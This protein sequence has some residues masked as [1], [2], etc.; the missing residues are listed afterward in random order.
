MK[1]PSSFGILCRIFA[2][3]NNSRDA[4]TTSQSK[5]ELKD[6]FEYSARL[7]RLTEKE[8]L[9]NSAGSYDVQINALNWETP[10]LSSISLD[11]SWGAHVGNGYIGFAGVAHCPFTG[12]THS[13]SNLTSLAKYRVTDRIETEASLTVG[14]N[15]QA[16]A[17]V[18][19]Q[20]SPSS[21]FRVSVMTANAAHLP[22]I[23]FF[24]SRQLTFHTTLFL[25]YS[26]SDDSGKDLGS[27]FDNYRLRN[28]SCRLGLIHM[29]SKKSLVNLNIQTGT[30]ESFVSASYSQ[31]VF[32]GIRFKAN[33]ELNTL[34][35]LTVGLQTEKRVTEYTKIG[36]GY[37]LS[38]STGLLLK[39]RLKRL[40]RRITVPLYLSRHFDLRQTIVLSVAIPL[41]QFIS[42]QA[43]FLPQYLKQ[44]EKEMTQQREEY[45]DTLLI[46]KKDAQDAVDV[47]F[48]SVMKKQELERQKHGLVILLAVYGK[49]PA[50][51]PL[52]DLKHLN[53]S[54]SNY[55]DVTIPVASLVQKSQ[56]FVPSRSK[57][58][59][60][61]F[62]DPCYPEEKHLAV[63]YLFHNR[64][65]FVKMR[66]R[67][68]LVAPLRSHVIAE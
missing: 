61:G 22:A 19:A 49:L 55:I 23:S 27:I 54:G 66:D 4:D 24:T 41:L 52:T 51:E 1:L 11:H 43:Y 38:N 53:P 65:H 31:A 8:N 50:I 62:Y 40:E 26:T 16:S 44:K 39:F 42:E 47:M 68:A 33:F 7:K 32:Q 48:S 15:P 28:R 10:H 9:T 37:S 35:G 58:S 60:L 56:L 18:S 64:V 20:F 17:S 36:M 67:D 63:W 3:S 45:A 2:T 21:M 57:T 46:R 6:L 5:E 29:P 25:S 14:S 34:L 13:A 30:V 59:L 12:E